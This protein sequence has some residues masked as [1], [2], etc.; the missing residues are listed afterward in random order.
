MFNQHAVNTV[1]SWTKTR[2]SH[3]SCF[4]LL[5][6]SCIFILPAF[7]NAAGNEYW[8]QWEGVF[9]IPSHHTV[10]SVH[11]APRGP[12]FPPCAFAWAHSG[13]T[14]LL[15][16]LLLSLMHLYSTLQGRGL[17]MGDH[18]TSLRC[19]CKYSNEPSCVDGVRDNGSIFYL[20]LLVC[21]SR[22]YLVDCIVVP[23]SAWFAGI[24]FHRHAS[25]PAPA[26]ANA[27]SFTR[28]SFQ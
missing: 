28:L 18:S 9:Q 26:D 15:L 7:V 20:P 8:Q 12:S 3:S 2:S 16:H 24:N 13:L 25:L 1:R 17:M 5:Q 21:D 14:F 4:H 11:L 19:S 27:Y 23:K 6:P 22:I 10:K